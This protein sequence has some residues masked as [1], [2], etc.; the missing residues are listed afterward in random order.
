MPNILVPLDGS[1][2]SERAVPLATQLAHA[3]GDQIRLE[4]SFTL[5]TV[6][7]VPGPPLDLEEYAR[8]YLTEQV[9]PLERA[10]GI[11]TTIVT[12]FGP[13]AIEIVAE[14]QRAD[15]S[16]VVMSTHGRRGLNHALL[17][18]VAEHVLRESPTPV[19]LLPDAAPAGRELEAIQRIAVALDGSDLSEAV[20]PQAI[21]LA[22]RFRAAVTL[23]RS[24]D[25]PED[26][27]WD[28]KHEHMIST[29]DQR[30]ERIATVA[31]QYLDPLVARVHAAGVEAASV[32]TLSSHPAEAIL[33]L[34]EIQGA[35]LIVMAT[36]GR[37]GLEHLRYGSVTEHVL[38]HSTLPLLV[39]GR[40]MLAG[41]G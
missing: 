2:L 6:V 31:A 38:R 32:Y 34:A 16:Y 15:V 22:Q 5:P 3:T 7:D 12:D 33:K 26:P 11:A 25:P 39:F 19:L 23:I 36:H 17:G 10:E 28:E 37:S 8:E 9:E 14:A 18:S 41:K 29:I 13:P 27:I 24:F 20:L 30:T 1:H 4:R 21:H 40:R 35:D